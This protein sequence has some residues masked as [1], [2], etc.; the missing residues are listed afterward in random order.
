MA[1]YKEILRKNL[2]PLLQIFMQ[3]LKN[4]THLVIYIYNLYTSFFTQIDS[5]MR[6]EG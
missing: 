4:H 6:H 5:G 3:F 2:L 1:K